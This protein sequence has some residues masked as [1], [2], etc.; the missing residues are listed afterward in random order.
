MTPETAAR[1]PRRSRR[2]LRGLRAQL[3]LWT[4]LPLAVL[5]VALSLAGVTRHRQAMTQLVKDRDRGLTAAEANRLGREIAQQT[6]SLAR[7]AATLSTAPAPSTAPLEDPTGG[8]LSGLVLLD[9]R[10]AIAAVGAAAAAGGARAPPRRSW[11]REPSQPANP[12]TRPT[13]QARAQRD[14]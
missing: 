13:S 8:G 3:L 4:I 6:A 11:L 10:G 14:C 1:P 2:F 12:S 5:L 7:L 9:A